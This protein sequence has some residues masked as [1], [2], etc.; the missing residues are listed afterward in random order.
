MAHTSGSSSRNKTLKIL[1]EEREE[2]L[3][4]LS[5]VSGKKMEA[6]E[7]R[8]KLFYGDLFAS[9]EYFPS[10]DVLPTGR[11]SCFENSSIISPEPLT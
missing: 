10:E 1:P 5:S 9:L 2:L 6:D 7:I 8:G 3:S 11:L 4:R